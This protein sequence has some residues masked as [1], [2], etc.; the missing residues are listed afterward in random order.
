MAGPE[1]VAEMIKTDLKTGLTDQNEK[2]R[3]LTYGS[4]EAKPYK[5][6]S[7]CALFFGAMNDFVLRILIVFA[8]VSLVA[9]MIFSDKRH[10]GKSKIQIMIYVS[11]DRECGNHDS[12]SRCFWSR[13]MERL[14]KREAVR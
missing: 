8:I 10:I 2:Y 1:A 11:L 12:S 3:D 13:S 6:S 7:F 14:V 9:E 4:N 5:P